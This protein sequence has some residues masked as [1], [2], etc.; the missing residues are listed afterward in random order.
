LVKVACNGS[1]SCGS[2]CYRLTVVV[3]AAAAAAAIVI[4]RLKPLRLDKE[5]QK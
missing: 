2:Y 4:I 5:L 3:V 1:S